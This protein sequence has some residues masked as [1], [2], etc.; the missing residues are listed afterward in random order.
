MFSSLS[1]L[2]VADDGRKQRYITIETWSDRKR[3][4]RKKKIKKRQNNSEK[5]N[6]RFHAQFPAAILKNPYYIPCNTAHIITPSHEIRIRLLYP[7]EIWLV[8][9]PIYQICKIKHIL[10]KYMIIHI[11]I[12]QRWIW[13]TYTPANSVEQIPS[14]RRTNETENT[15]NIKSNMLNRQHENNPPSAQ[16]V[17]EWKD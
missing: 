5:L 7:C 11:S 2:T 16:L 15:L 4:F 10:N 3:E 1:I 17:N 13:H 9:F 6:T 12:A 8:E 14:E